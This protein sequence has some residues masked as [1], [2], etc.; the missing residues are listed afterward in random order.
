[1]VIYHG[2]VDLLSLH[3]RPIWCTESPGAIDFTIRPL[4]VPL[5]AKTCWNFRFL[6]SA[7]GVFPTFDKPPLQSD[8][9]RQWRTRSTRHSESHGGIRFTVR[10]LAVPRQARMCRNFGILNPT[11]GVLSTLDRPLLQLD[12]PTGLPTRPTRPAESPSGICFTVCALAVALQARMCWKFRFSNEP[13]PPWGAWANVRGR[14]RCVQPESRRRSGANLEPMWRAG[15]NVRS[16]SQVV[17][18]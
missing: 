7:K 5:E 8:R 6:N 4:A 12:S 10:P 14:S 16:Q 2:T 9:P 3:S 1:M 11:G 18:P 15:A 17:D 13:T